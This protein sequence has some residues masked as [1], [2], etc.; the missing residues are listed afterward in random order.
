M[1]LGFLKCLGVRECCRASHPPTHIHT[2]Q[3]APCG[4]IPTP[5]CCLSPPV[6]Q[7]VSENV[8]QAKRIGLEHLSYLGSGDAHYKTRYSKY[9]SG[10]MVDYAMTV[11]G[12]RMIALCICAAPIFA[13][14]G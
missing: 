7:N 1:R 8:Y 2:R 3:R 11:T 14:H 6:Y 10:V 13:G 5:F 9:F 12:V 4:T